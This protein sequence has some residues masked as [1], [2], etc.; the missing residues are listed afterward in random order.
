MASALAELGI[1]NTLATDF[2]NGFHVDNDICYHIPLSLLPFLI[3]IMLLYILAG[4]R[5]IMLRKVKIADIFVLF[6]PSKKNT[7]NVQCL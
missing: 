3:Q 5:R 1:S 6:L 4:I 7:S 2:K